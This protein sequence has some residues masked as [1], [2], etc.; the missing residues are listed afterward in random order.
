MSSNWTV[1]GFSIGTTQVLYLWDKKDAHVKLTFSGDLDHVQLSH[2]LCER[3]AECLNEQE[4]R[5]E[6]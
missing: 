6:R 3:I 2:S 4:P 1:K 5:D